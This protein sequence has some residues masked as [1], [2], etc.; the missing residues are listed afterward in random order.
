LKIDNCVI[1]FVDWYKKS[2]KRAKKY[3]LKYYDPPLKEK[4]EI[5][6]PM[7]EFCKGLEHVTH[8]RNRAG[9]SEIIL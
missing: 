2:I 6:K 8:P 1:N 9:M 7:A 3:G 5:I 4:I